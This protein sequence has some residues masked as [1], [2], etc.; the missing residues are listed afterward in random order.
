M[1]KVDLGQANDMKSQREPVASRVSWLQGSLEREQGVIPGHRAHPSWP[2]SNS[3]EWPPEGK[4]LAGKAS[5]FL[6]CS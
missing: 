5:S 2:F 4:V 6:Q 3:L 1:Q